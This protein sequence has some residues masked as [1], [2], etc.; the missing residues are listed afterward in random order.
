[1]TEQSGPGGPGLGDGA[2]E[3]DGLLRELNGMRHAPAEHRAG[4]LERVLAFAAAYP[5]DADAEFW[6]PE[7]WEDLGRAYAELGRVDEA[8]RAVGEAIEAGLSGSP[9]PR[10]LL[11]EINYQAGR[12][13]VAQEIWACLRAET[14]DDVWLYNLVGMA[15]AEGGEHTEAVLWLGEGLRIAIATGDPERLV[16]QLSH[17]RAACLRALDEGEDGLQ[18]TA[19]AFLA[20][21]QPVPVPVRAE[22]RPSAAGLAVPPEGPSPPGAGDA[23]ATRLGMAW[24]PS[25]EYRAAVSRWPALAGEDGP[26]STPGGGVAS[27]RDYCRAIEGHLAQLQEASLDQGG[28]VIELVVVPLRVA[29]LDAWAAGHE[30][31]SGSADARAGLTSELT[32]AGKG[33]PW[34]PA[35]KGDC[36]C[37]SGRRYKRCCGA[38]R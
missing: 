28:P 18:R 36:W 4:V 35:A 12:R 32:R 25:G 17:A 6:L 23:A 8:L 24:F 38:D 13:D 5:E 37:G 3:I 11:G 21:P 7:I 15:L 20:A 19:E 2:V 1:M 9:D 27:H 34:P 14:P 10:A 22:A 30:E 33:R 26:A 16:D 29:T 31:D